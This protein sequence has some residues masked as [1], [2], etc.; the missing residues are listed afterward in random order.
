MSQTGFTCKC[1]EEGY[2]PDCPL[3]FVQNGQI[4]HVLNNDN[5]LKPRIHQKDQQES[6]KLP[7][8]E[9]EYKTESR[10]FI[11]IPSSVGKYQEFDES[12]NSDDPDHSYNLT[13][14]AAY[15]QAFAAVDLANRV[16]KERLE[17]TIS[18][19]FQDG[20]D[21]MTTNREVMRKFEALKIGEQSLTSMSIGGFTIDLAKAAQKAKEIAPLPPAKLPIIFKDPE[22]NFYHHFFQGLEMLIGR[23]TLID[24]ANTNAYFS[25]GND[26]LYGLIEDMI[27][28]GYERSDTELTV[29]TKTVL[30]STFG[31]DDIN[32]HAASGKHLTVDANLWGLQYIECGMQCK[33]VD[34]KMWLS[35][36]YSHYRT[37]WFNTFKSSGIP[38]FALEGVQS[39]YEEKPIHRMRTI[40]EIEPVMQ[41][42]QS[43]QLE[44][45]KK[46]VEKL[47]RSNRRHES[48]KS[49]HRSSKGGRSS[50]SVV[51]SIFGIKK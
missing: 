30:T 25:D 13:N 48:K 47:E 37:L 41:I 50:D 15:Q 3:A 39:R 35:I 32:D 42:A 5:K 26:L 44:L 7:L 24:L 14:D 23:N 19:N 11:Q 2:S 36:C 21:M 1:S 6:N 4:L 12:S 20:R 18:S 45:L 33:E 29:F 22:M 49:S 10:E 9:R 40:N 31:L 8:I 34:L 43:N 16:K 51:D 28:K 17:S 46:N 38:N 27:K